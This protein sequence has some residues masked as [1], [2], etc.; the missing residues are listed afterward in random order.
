MK[1]IKSN[2][3]NHLGRCTSKDMGPKI[4]SWRTL[5]V[6]R[7]S[8]KLKHTSWLCKPSIWVFPNNGV[9]PNQ[10][11]RWLLTMVHYS[12]WRL[13]TIQWVVM[14]T[15]FY[16]RTSQNDVSFRVTAK[17]PRN[18]RAKEKALKLFAHEQFQYTFIMPS[19]QG[20]GAFLWNP[21][22][23]DSPSLEKFTE[24]GHAGPWRSPQLP[25]LS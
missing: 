18:A 24:G 8:K 10:L 14:C 19:R 23:W 21:F 25:S 16:F 6:L 3:I 4:I 17:A 2:R 1:K 15:E 7:L 22:V 9:T 13:I 20:V 11:R 12:S 5:L